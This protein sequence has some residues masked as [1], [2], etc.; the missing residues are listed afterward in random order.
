MHRDEP[1]I[2]FVSRLHLKRNRTQYSDFSLLQLSRSF[3]LITDR[4]KSMELSC[5]GLVS[6]AGTL[7]VHAHFS[8]RYPSSSPSPS[9]FLSL[10]FL[11]CPTPCDMIYSRHLFSPFSLRRLFPFAL[12]HFILKTDHCCSIQRPDG[13]WYGS[14]GVCFTYGTWFGIEALMVRSHNNLERLRV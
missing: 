4:M 1:N 7:L 9:S 14:W 8:M 5:E 13:S 10:E 6:S 12:R 2:L 11:S 3:I